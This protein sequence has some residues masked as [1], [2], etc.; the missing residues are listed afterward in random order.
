MRE[1]KIN[2][3]GRLRQQSTDTTQALSYIG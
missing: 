1:F 3:P 2:V